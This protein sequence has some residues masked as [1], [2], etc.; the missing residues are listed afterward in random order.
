MDGS[1][2]AHK[3]SPLLQQHGPPLADRCN[4][5]PPFQ[6]ALWG[7]AALIYEHELWT[8]DRYKKGRIE[9]SRVRVPVNRRV[10]L[11]AYKRQVAEWERRLRLA[12]PK[13]K[14][15]THLIDKMGGIVPFCLA[16]N[17][18]PDYILYKWLGVSKKGNVY[19]KHG[20]I[21]SMG[22][23]IRILYAARSFGVLLKPEDLFPDLIENDVL[24]NPYT[25]PE[26]QE[27]WKAMEPNIKVQQLETQIAALLE[28]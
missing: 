7:E 11:E 18:H 2:V 21:P 9:I 27:W 20:L 12:K 6:S 1:V 13:H 4:C 8:K 3:G 5:L 26:L 15:I 23:L 14:Q 17:K 28:D 24:K 25:N 16:L 19:P 10:K 22:Y